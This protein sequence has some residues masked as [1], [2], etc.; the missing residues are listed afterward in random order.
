MKKIFYP[1]LILTLFTVLAQPVRA[2]AADPKAGAVTTSASQL[3]VRSAPSTS[4]PVVA[5]LKK[6]SYIT[7]LSKSGSWW[8]VQYGPNHYGYCHADYITP[9]AGIATSVTADSLNVRTGPGKS[10]AVTGYL[11][12]G[13]SVIV[14]STANGWSRIL[15]HGTKTGYASAQYLSQTFPS[16]SLWVPN[17]KQ[18]D[19][20]WAQV[21][22][23]QTGKTMAQIGCATT[24][25][26]MVESHRR[27]YTIYPDAMTRELTYTPGGSVYWP[28][29]YTTV[30]GSKD[31]SAI[32]TRL[33][34]GKP[35]LL[36]VLNPEGSQHW[37]VVTGYTGGTTL[38]PDRFTIQ[39][40][41]TYHRTNLQ[42]LLALYPTFYKY[43]Y[44]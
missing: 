31:L 28:S 40:P 19:S 2:A 20:R 41:G 10:H 37:V 17:L 25:I 26:A 7:L 1:L 23:G 6:G 8:R 4:G 5:S 14:L 3:N 18:M 38:S 22:I 12:R 21:P 44:Y 11:K 34:Q 29:H 30:N 32:Y 39:D 43:F 16:V 36:G 35:V 33:R 15:Y 42:Q 27:G 24:A 9:I 13:E